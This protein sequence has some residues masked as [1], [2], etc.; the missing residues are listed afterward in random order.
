V[1]IS[2]LLVVLAVALTVA[3]LTI[4]SVGVVFAAPSDDDT[5]AVKTCDS[6]SIELHAEEKRTF[7]AHN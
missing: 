3:M 5:V 7:D 1:V 6:E 4:L 2:R